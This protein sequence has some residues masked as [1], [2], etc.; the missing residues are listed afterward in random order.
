MSSSPSWQRLT[1]IVF[2]LQMR[3]ARSRWRLLEENPTAGGTHRTRYAIVRGEEVIVEAS[4]V[5]GELAGEELLRR[6]K[7]WAEE[8]VGELPGRRG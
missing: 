3:D 4:H 1:G 8:H 2:G 5:V 6:W 7:A